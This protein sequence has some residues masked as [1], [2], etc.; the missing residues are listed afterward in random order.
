M[1]YAKAGAAS[2]LYLALLFLVYYL[3]VRFGRVNVVLYSA[4][5]DVVIATSIAWAIIWLVPAFRIFSVFEKLQMLAIWLLAGY[6]FAISLPTV[7]DRS[8]SFYILEK[9]QQ[10]GGGIRRADF[11]N[12]FT[13]EYVKEHRL[14]DI[15]LTEQVE[16]G[17]IRIENGCVK[18]T[19]RGNRMA[20]FSRFFRRHLLPTERLIG[21]EY[22]D[23][24]TDPFRN[25]V[26]RNDYRCQ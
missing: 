20:S 6:A 1:K 10:R 23:D 21:G 4:V 2:V 24:L 12:V 3:H 13:E 18:L 19:D 26:E 25:S 11:E 16:S 17:T 5:L 7:I 15:R 9:I 8:L 14:V 22:S